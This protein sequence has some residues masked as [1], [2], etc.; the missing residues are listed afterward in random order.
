[1]SSTSTIE[2]GANSIITT[3]FS[4]P[5]AYIEPHWYVA[6]TCAQHEKRVAEQ[7]DRRCIENFLPLYERVSRWKDRR[8]RL[9]QPLFSGYVFVRLA[10]RERLRVL[11]IQSVARLVGFGGTPVALPDEEMDGIRNSL[12]YQMRAEPYPY[13]AV[14]QRVFLQSGPLQGL[15]GIL[16]RRKQRVRLVV[17]VAL[18]QRSI[19]VEVDAAD[20]SALPSVR[21]LVT[22]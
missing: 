21:E 22:T 6:Q 16:V 11:E 8:V 17:S 2:S 20:V 10:L 12:K 5:A 15:E 1:M 3:S 14:G 13:L 7:L 19:A 4:L 18:I 9:Q